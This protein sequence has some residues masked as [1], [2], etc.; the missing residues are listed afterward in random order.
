MSR[1][2]QLNSLVELVRNH[3]VTVELI[4]VGSESDG[5]YLVPIVVSQLDYC[6]SP[7]VSDSVAFER[8]LAK[9]Y[10]IRSYMIDASIDQLPERSEFY[11]FSKKFLGTNTDENFITLSSWISMCLA[12]DNFKG[13]LQMDIEG[14]E[15]DILAFES[16]E[17]LSRFS[18][19]V[20]EF[21]N[22]ERLFDPNFALIFQSILHKIFINFSICH[23]HPNNCCGIATFN[24]VA[25]PRVLEITF[26]RNDLLDSTHKPGLNLPH[27]LDCANDISVRDLQM[28]EIWWKQKH[29]D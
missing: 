22:L 16:A 6:F 28:P 19:M 1:S 4:R 3:S 23:L 27:T 2:S 20:I 13:I 12:D 7:G 29:K 25:V 11:N 9:D 14:G 26:I 17:S 15:Y 8:H 5:G 10:G 21:H 18:V 24:G